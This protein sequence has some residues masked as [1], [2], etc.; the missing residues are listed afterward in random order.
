MSR[1][2][3]VTNS[4]VR[5]DWREA[6]HGR[7][8]DERDPFRNASAWRDI[9]IRSSS[10]L[11]PDTRSGIHWLH[12]SRPRLSWLVF[13]LLFQTWTNGVAWIPSL[14]LRRSDC[15]RRTPVGGAI[16]QPLLVATNPSVNDS[17]STSFN[18]GTV[19]LVLSSLAF[20]LG[21][22]IFT[23]TMVRARVPPR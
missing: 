14:F 15:R 13:Q 22:L 12:D 18:A 2:S 16:V 23:S 9:G 6:S 8:R 21:Y 3:V 11:G 1:R 4:F 7:G 19:A 10:N 5:E 20:L 17:L